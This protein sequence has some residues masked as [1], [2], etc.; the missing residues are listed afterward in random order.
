M[1]F[2][3]VILLLLFMYEDT[4]TENRVVN[5]SVKY[6]SGT[7]H[8]SRLTMTYLHNLSQGSCA[9]L[10]N[11]LILHLFYSVAVC[12]DCYLTFS[13]HCSDI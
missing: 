6:V 13:V 9:C 7:V 8:S 4:F 1:T 5:A 2:L 10:Q 3:V 11:T 12:I